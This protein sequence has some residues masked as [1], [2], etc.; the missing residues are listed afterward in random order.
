MNND[1]DNKQF[2]ANI[3]NQLE[4]CENN[5]DGATASKL[6]QARYY[7][8]NTCNSSLKQ[9]ANNNHLR[10]RL[11]AFAAAGLASIALMF[12]VFLSTDIGN[13]INDN[14][15]FDNN[16]VM[17]EH[18]YTAYIDSYD[19]IFDHYESSIDNYDNEEYEIYQFLDSI[20]Q[21]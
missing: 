1:S 21:S 15:P 6:T 4:D 8:L 7:A 17:S 18:E 3:K 20:E 5:I 9:N 14:G 12:A 16:Y 11:P 10:L 2:I 19:P 13:S